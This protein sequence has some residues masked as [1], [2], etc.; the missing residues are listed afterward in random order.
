VANLFPGQITDVRIWNRVCSEEEIKKE[1][2]SL[3]MGQAPGL[4]GY[5]PLKEATGMTVP[6]YT[7]YGHDAAI[8]TSSWESLVGLVMIKNQSNGHQNGNG[9]Y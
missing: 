2:N 3:A 4:V 1:M 9:R 8:N 7:S 6:D 5:W